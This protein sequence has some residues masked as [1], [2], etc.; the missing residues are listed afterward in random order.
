MARILKKTALALLLMFFVAAQ[1]C[2]AADK[3]GVVLMHGKD[4]IPSNVSAIADA[5]RKNGF[6]VVTPEMPFSRDRQFDKSWDACVPEI[7]NAVA[8]LKKEGA[9]TI[10]VGG[11]SLGAAMALYY[12]TK[13]AVAGVL[14]IAPGGNTG[15]AAGLVRDEIGRA[16]KM[17]AEGKGD[18][19]GLFDDYNQGIRHTRRTTA[20]IYLSYQDPDGPA[21]I[22][23]VAT[24]LKPG[25]PLLWVV[26]TKDPMY[27]MGAPFA[28]GKAPAD[29]RSKYIVI[30]AAGHMDTAFD[31]G[32]IRQ[33]VEWINGVRAAGAAR[34]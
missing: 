1:V 13:T 21:V 11:H 26:G 18:S 2:G 30:E 28:F 15:H 32:A 12:G 16:R 7:D 25:T 10:F 3:A 14:A 34:P 9:G 23:R 19:I 20:N 31:S 24:A 33:V 17:A 4:G 8:Y 5:L 22:P 29:S 27:E 6:I